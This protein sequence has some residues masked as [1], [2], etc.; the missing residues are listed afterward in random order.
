MT[1]NPSQL[2]LMLV[3][4]ALT[5]EILKTNSKHNFLFKPST[6]EFKLKILNS[7]KIS[8]INSLKKPTSSS[9]NSDLN[10]LLKLLYSLNFK[11][12][13]D[14]RYLNRTVM[15]TLRWINLSINS[16]IYVSNKNSTLEQSY[17][18]TLLI[19]HLY[20]TYTLKKL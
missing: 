3:I 12:S 7:I 18:F 16:Q 14:Q 15:N 2:E 19:Q 8:N 11:D 6:Q 1:K 4:L 10:L 20:Q 9:F 17:F 5:N 13:S